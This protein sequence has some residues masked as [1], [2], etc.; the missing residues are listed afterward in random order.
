VAAQV[1]SIAAL[2]D[3]TLALPY[4]S[5]GYMFGAI[6]LYSHFR[7]QKAYVQKNDINKKISIFLILS[8]I[9]MM[10]VIFWDVACCNLEEIFLHVEGRTAC[11]FRLPSSLRHTP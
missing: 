7:T 4:L 5:A 10:N 8:A 2:D 11:I 1:F 6:R 3:S 9:T